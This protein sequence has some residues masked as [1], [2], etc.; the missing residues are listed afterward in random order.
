MY[1]QYEEGMQYAQENV[2]YIKQCYMPRVITLIINTKKKVT[3]D[4]KVFPK[5]IHIGGVMNNVLELKY[6]DND[7][8][9]Q[10]NKNNCEMY[11]KSFKKR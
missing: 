5:G 9:M 11:F 7:Y 3:A 4:V 1:F 10:N 8:K 2:R 6:E